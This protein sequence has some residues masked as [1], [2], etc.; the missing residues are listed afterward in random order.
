MMG[1]YLLRSLRDRKQYIGS[2]TN[3]ERRLDQHNKGY[4]VS[5]KFRRPLDLIGY[6]VCETIQE[7]VIYEKK[8][9][10]SHGALERAIKKGKFLLLKI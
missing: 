9:K 8:Y 1:V 5:T 2:T 3:L 6:Q 7:A 10:S 4:V